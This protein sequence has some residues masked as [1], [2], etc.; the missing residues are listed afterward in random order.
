MIQR[1][2]ENNEPPP[3]RGVRSVWQFIFKLLRLGIGL[4]LLGL[5]IRDVD[6]AAFLN[7]IQQVS[8]GWMTVVLLT[9]LVTLVLKT[10]RWGLLLRPVVPELSSGNIL[11]ALLV[12]QAANIL[13]PLRSGD[14]IRS[15]M[16]SVDDAAR[17]PAVIT[18]LI[19]EKGLDALMLVLAMALTLP[20]LPDEVSLSSDGRRLLGLGLGALTVALLAIMLSRRVWHWMRRPLRPLP[21]WVAQKT[22]SL[23]DRFVEGMTQLRLG[24]QFGMVMILTLLSWVA[25]FLTNLT[26][27]YSLRLA[28]PPAAGLLVMVLV[29]LGIIPRL[30]PGQVGPFY[31]FARLALAQFGVESAASTAYAVVLHAAFMIPPLV[32]AG[33]YL[34]VTKRRFRPGPAAGG[35]PA[36]TDPIVTK[37]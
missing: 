13:L 1:S 8:L 35:E 21:G 25:M 4:A 2:S 22:L 19:I 10:W 16:A 3:N 5:A 14:L 36:A 23:G 31:F 7:A 17:L 27:A 33:L 37:T 28:V 18:G 26:M 32:G 29:F 11:G 6:F 34:M 30:M 9:I 24:G 20:V 15:L 12:G